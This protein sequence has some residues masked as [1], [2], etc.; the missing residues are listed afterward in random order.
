[1]CRLLKLPYLRLH[2]EYP[3][4]YSS[5]GDVRQQESCSS[6]H[7]AELA[8]VHLPCLVKESGHVVQLRLRVRPVTKITAGALEHGAER[9]LL[10]MFD[11]RDHLLVDEGDGERAGS[12]DSSIFFQHAQISKS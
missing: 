10:K 2:F 4:F 12:K 5:R 3:P 1:M 8:H 11:H 9:H 6:W 7:P